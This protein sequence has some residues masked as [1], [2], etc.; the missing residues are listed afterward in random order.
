MEIKVVNVGR[1]LQMRQVMN[2]VPGSTGLGYGI[3]FSI[4]VS[5]NHKSFV[6]ADDKNQGQGNGQRN[7]QQPDEGN[8]KIG[9]EQDTGAE[10]GQQQKQRGMSDWQNSS[11]GPGQGEQGERSSNDPGKQNIY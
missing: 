5:I 2:R 11:S 4:I 9:M 6:M 1:R 10:M 3:G 8:A 7:S